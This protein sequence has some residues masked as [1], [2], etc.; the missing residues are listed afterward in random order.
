MTD[1]PTYPEVG[2]TRA[3]ALP[4]GYRHVRRTVR[5]GSG[6]EPF[7]RLVAGM[8]DWRIHR[9]AGLTV[10]V[11]GPPTPGLRFVTGIGFGPLRLSAPCR[12]VWFVDEP[13]R[14]GFGFGTLPGHPE[15]GEES[16]LAEWTAE[17]DVYFHVTAFSRPAAWYAR[18]GAAPARRVQDRVTDR[19]VASAVAL[20]GP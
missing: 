7:H 3:G 18:L 19:Y 14:Y 10:R 2:A 17:D 20:A 11:D 5:L 13:D 8:A 12:I 16:F 6:P 1:D 4:T 15:R 9:D